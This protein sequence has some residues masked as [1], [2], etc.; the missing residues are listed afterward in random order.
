WVVPLAVVA[1]WA[2]TMTAI[3]SGGPGD[4]PGATLFAAVPG[5]FCLVGAASASTY[6]R[7]SAAGRPPLDTTP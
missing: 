4:E 1:L 3:M 7:W 6:L 5:V 2:V